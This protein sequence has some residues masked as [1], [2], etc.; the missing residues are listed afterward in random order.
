MLEKVLHILFIYIGRDASL[1]FITGD[2][3]KD[4][5]DDLSSLSIQ[6]IKALH[7]WVQFYNTN[8]IY[9]GIII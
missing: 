8:Y 1:S 4:L 3:N 9:K 2:F 6:Q 5:T 7:D